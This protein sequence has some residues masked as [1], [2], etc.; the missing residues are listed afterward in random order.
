MKQHKYMIPETG[1]FIKPPITEE[2][3]AK[4]DFFKMLCDEIKKQAA[5]PAPKTISI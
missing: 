1:H 4:E 2:Q 3:K 5:L